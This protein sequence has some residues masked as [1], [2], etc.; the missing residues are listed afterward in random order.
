M[1]LTT[2]LLIGGAA[3]AGAGTVSTVVGGIL[4]HKEQLQDQKD[5]IDYEYE[6]LGR[7]DESPEDE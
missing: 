3:L 7:R 1:V 4:Q 5:L 6:K 2:A